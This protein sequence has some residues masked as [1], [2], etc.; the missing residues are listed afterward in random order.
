MSARKKRATGKTAAGSYST[1]LTSTPAPRAPARE[2]EVSKRREGTS[3]TS[4][5]DSF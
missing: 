3:M 1:Y 4:A 2:E 5:A